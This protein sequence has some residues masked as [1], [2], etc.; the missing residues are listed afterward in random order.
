[1]SWYSYSRI[2]AY[3][4][5]QQGQKKLKKLQAG[6]LEIEPLGEILHRT[7]IAES[8]WGRAWCRHLESFS[9]YSNRLPRGR[10]YLRQGAVL[11]LTISHC[12][13]HALV[14]GSNLYEQT[15]SIAPLPPKKWEAI[16]ARCRGKISSLIELLQGRL[17]DEIMAVVTDH[18]TGI[19]PSSKE[20]RFDCSCPDWA[21]M[22]K[23]IAAVLYG[24]GVKLDQ[25]PELL[26]RLRGV[27]VQDLI[28]APDPAG[29]LA[30][31]PDSGGRRRLA[32]A[33]VADVFGI[34]VEDVPLDS[35]PLQPQSS[36]VEC[37]PSAS[38]KRPASEKSSVKPRRKK[39][40][41]IPAGATLRDL[42]KRLK[43][44]TASLAVLLNVSP[45]ALHNWERKK[46]PF[47]IPVTIRNKINQ[48]QQV[49][50]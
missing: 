11:H 24:V 2:S 49:I 25:S 43:L 29:L 21:D 14:Q 32:S 4:A 40:A 48:L 27:N 28:A 7:K 20:I 16:Q 35:P 22:C 37:R 33:D 5:D 50:P 46:G 44:S 13:I 45:Q 17:S 6:G 19:F 47:E 30:N 23:H 31:S 38:K 1:M 12:K 18:E 8:F 26:F 36:K 3:E 42:R 34:E 39:D 15:I 10:S 41:S 9:D